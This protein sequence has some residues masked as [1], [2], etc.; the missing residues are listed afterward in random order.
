MP[1]I[2]IGVGL[3]LIGTV[4]ASR[5]EAKKTERLSALMDEQQALREKELALQKSE[6]DR[7]MRINKR[8]RSAALARTYAGRG[9]DTERM[10]LVE[11]GIRSSFEGAQSFLDQ[12][13]QNQLGISGLGTEMSKLQA[14]P[15]MGL[16]SQLMV[17]G[18]S[19]G[20]QYLTSQGVDKGELEE[21]F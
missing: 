18:L 16:G 20:S 21:Y 17:G 9:L 19:L 10:D 11:A 6:K 14:Q 7:Q 1:Q 13:F 3:S 4:I 12:S 8:I 5:A 2:A 15:S